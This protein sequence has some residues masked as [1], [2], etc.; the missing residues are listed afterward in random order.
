MDSYV[1]AVRSGDR[2]SG[3]ANEYS[4]SLPTETMPRGKQ[5]RATVRWYAPNS[6]AMQVRSPNIVRHASTTP[7]DP[8]ATVMVSTPTNDTGPGVVYFADAPSALDVRYIGPATRAPLTNMIE[9]EFSLLF[10]SV[11][12]SKR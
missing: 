5:W 12:G 2:I 6:A 9:H 11:E 1:I 10:E 7:G 4:I 3:T 8:W